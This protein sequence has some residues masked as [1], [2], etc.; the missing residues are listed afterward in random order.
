MSTVF[1]GMAASL[2]GFIASENG[3][4]AWL[5]DAMAKDEDYGF[6]ATE[7][8]TGAYVMGANTYRDVSRMGG[9]GSRI[10]TYVVTHDPTLVAT[11]N[12]ELFSGDLGDLVS[13]IRKSIPEDKDICLFGG[14]ELVTQF[15]E[16]GLIDELGVSVI[17]VILG[18]GVPFFG[19]L[20]QRR[21]LELLECRHYP[22]GIVLLNYRVR[23]QGA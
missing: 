22:S 17:P 5:N 11:G 20:G 7:R 10:P 9:G 23:A 3:D 18:G 12:T 15:V 21:K 6:E 1:G 13:R 16:H 8:R 14:G 2:D 4:L 19:R